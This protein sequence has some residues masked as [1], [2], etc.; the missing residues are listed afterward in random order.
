MAKHESKHARKPSAKLSSEKPKSSSSTPSFS[1]SNFSLL[2]FP[3]LSSLMGSLL[4]LKH[5]HRK[6]RLAILFS[7]L[8]AILSVLTYR[9]LGTSNSFW[10]CH[11]SGGVLALRPI[12][13]PVIAQK[14]WRPPSEEVWRQFGTDKCTIERVSV[15]DL[16]SE[17]FEQEFRFK[18]SVIVIFPNGAA[19]WTNPEDW[20]KRGLTKSYSQWTIHSGE[21]LEIVRKGGNAKHVSSFEEYVDNL[22]MEERSENDTSE[23]KH[24]A[25]DRQF[26]WFSKLGSSLRLPVYFQ[27]NTTSDESIFFL[28]PSL[29]G[30]VFHKH[31]DT[32]NGVVYGY[33]RWFLYPNTRTPP[34][35]VYHGYSLMNW[36]KHV[37]PNL[38]E[39]DKPMECI[40][41]PGEILYL[42]EGT[43]HATLNLG[44]T[45]AV[46]IQ[47]K[48]ATVRPEE[49][50][51]EATQL[52]NFLQTQ[53]NPHPKNTFNE[54][55]LEIY[56]EWHEL[57]PESSEAVLKLGAVLY[58]MQEYAESVLWY[59]KAIEMDQYFI[60]AYL[61]LGKAL[62]E[63]RQYTEAEKSFLK[64]I[65]LS[66]ELWDNYR[67]YGEFLLKRGRNTDAL[68]VYKKGTELMPDLIPFWFYYK[69]C[70]VHVGDLEGAEAS[71]KMIEEI[72]AKDGI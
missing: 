16:T 55:L 61:H 36:V 51:Y 1:Q 15:R 23:P 45:V 30:V 17:R 62:T 32:W 13:E 6:V 57:L 29:S 48:K 46:A 66:P 63:L 40:Q 56:R 10:I 8:V 70:Q 25:C 52:T 7:A 39:E 54:R 59:K 12:C 26:F 60:M 49:L 14:E 4:P 38:P 34:G 3:S 21:S 67:E 42:A 35:G 31:S 64:A 41:A 44:D 69:L 33:K 72:K 20:S 11:I 50:S 43:Y 58:D 27:I 24:Y 53:E 71:Q 9:N 18:K 28:G 37:Y 65:E 19:D 68:P 22:L 5:I 47:R 2:P